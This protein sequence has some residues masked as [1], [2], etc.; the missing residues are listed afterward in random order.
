VPAPL[1]LS[2]IAQQREPSSSAPS[3][4]EAPRSLVVSSSADDFM[5]VAPAP[6]QLEDGLV[7]SAA[8]APADVASAWAEPSDAG[9]LP[10]ASA[11]R[12]RVIS[13]GMGS[14]R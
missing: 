10:G 5:R 4:I 12:H 11:Q 7:E 6:L 1:A 8:V 2:S 14:A 13:P 9:S 3:P